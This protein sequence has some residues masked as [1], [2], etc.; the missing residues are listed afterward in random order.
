[1]SRYYWRKKN[2][3]WN[4]WIWFYDW[5]RVYFLIINSFHVW[6]IEVN[7]SP[8]V[9][10]S[11]PVTEVCVK[12]ALPTLLNIVLYSSEQKNKINSYH[13]KIKDNI[14]QDKQIDIKKEDYGYWS[15]LVKDPT[16]RI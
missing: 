2:V 14:I 7:S 15:E 11:T 10:Y 6:L 3:F 13:R 16:L 8:D 9:T 1:M 12:Q 4:V 5:F